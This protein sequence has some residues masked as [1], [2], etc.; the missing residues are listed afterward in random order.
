M[1]NHMFVETYVLV[2]KHTLLPQSQDMKHTH[3]YLLDM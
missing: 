3:S 1:Y 2:V